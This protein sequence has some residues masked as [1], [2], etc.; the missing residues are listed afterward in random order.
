MEHK[1]VVA[2]ETMI[3]QMLKLVNK[4]NTHHL[5]QVSRKLKRVLTSHHYILL[6]IYMN[7]VTLYGNTNKKHERIVELCDIL[8]PV[9]Q[10]LEGSSKAVAFMLIARIGSQVST[11]RAGNEELLKSG[12]IEESLTKFDDAYTLIK[13]DVQAPDSLIEVKISLTNLKE[14][15]DSN[16]KDYMKLDK[17]DEHHDKDNAYYPPSEENIE[18]L[19]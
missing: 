6:E 10:K 4:N 9:L 7:L 5:E 12:W 13:S 18:K 17:K 16:D 1:K 14:E 3:G 15:K 11:C 19:V 8:I 2:I